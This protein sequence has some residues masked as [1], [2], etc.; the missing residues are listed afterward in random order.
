MLFSSGSLPGEDSWPSPIEWH[1]LNASIGGRL[2]HSVPPGSV[3]YPEWPNYNTKAC[4]EVIS[5]WTAAKFHPSN[6]ISIN[7]PVWTNSSCNPIFPNGTSVTGDPHAGEKGCSIGSYPVYVINATDA[8][9]VQGA[10][11]FAQR[12][13]LRTNIKNMGLNGSG[14]IWTHHMKRI[15]YT[16]NS[17][18]TG[19]LNRNGS[20]QMT[21]TLGAGIQ[22]GELFDALP[23]HNVIAVGGI[24]K[25]SSSQMTFSIRTYSRLSAGGGGGTFRVVVNLTLK[26]FLM[27]SVVVCDL[28]LSAR[29]G[30]CAKAW[31]DLIARVH[32]LL[33]G[34]LD[35]GLSRYYIIK[36]PPGF[37][38]VT[39]SGSL[40]MDDA[41]VAAAEAAMR[42]LEQLLGAAKYTVTWS[43]GCV[44][45]DTFSELI[46]Q[47]P[48]FEN[49]GTVNRISAS[50]LLTRDTLKNKQDILAQT[51]KRVAPR[52]DGLPNYSVSGTLTVSQK[53]I[54]NALNPAWRNT[55][56]HFITSRLLDDSALRE[57]DRGSGSYLNGANAFEPG[58]QWSFF[59]ANYTRLREIKRRYDPDDLLWCPQYVGSEGWAQDDTC[60]LC[61]LYQ[62]F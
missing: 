23:L 39:Y 20:G 55:T 54:H 46:S 62:P 49:V 16:A 61:P 37:S 45:F 18:A 50:R 43:T 22:E 58:W 26:A 34:A 6:P 10:L 35:K 48:T 44:R 47:L 21:F 8:S 38:M 29:N 28:N 13:N 60:R 1:S 7:S 24:T 14:S 32:R 42:P 36:G 41:E 33:P 4:D 2:I 57:L 53:P 12:W 25:T 30:T 17:I 15:D 11:R 40:F 9:H 31:W 59:G 27:P 56:V 52:A 3:C 5:Q 19:S 51:L